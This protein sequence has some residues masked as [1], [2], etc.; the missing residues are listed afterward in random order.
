MLMK[1][2]KCHGGSL[3][4][5]EG[6]GACGQVDLQV[7]ELRSIKESVRTKHL[8]ARQMFKE[9]LLCARQCAGCYG[10]AVVRK[11]MGVPAF[12]R[13]TISKGRQTVTQGVAP[14]HIKW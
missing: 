7:P 13:L 5:Q 1:H 3:V 2:C 4:Q 9:G 10:N 8:F 12:R 11:E 14:I 6:G